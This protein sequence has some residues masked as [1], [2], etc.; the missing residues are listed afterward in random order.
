MRI[1]KRIFDSL[2]VVLGVVVVVVGALKI[3]KMK[4]E[5]FSYSQIKN[6]LLVVVVDVV[7]AEKDG[8]N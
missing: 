2:V 6:F 4:N 7:G 8:E 3:K 1:F 5:F